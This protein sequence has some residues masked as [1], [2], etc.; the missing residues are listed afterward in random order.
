M[1]T[2]TIA[3]TIKTDTSRS[4]KTTRTIVCF[5]ILDYDSLTYVSVGD[6]H[7]QVVA[8]I[9]KKVTISHTQDREYL[10]NAQASGVTNTKL[11]SFPLALTELDLTPATDN[12][13]YSG[14][15]DVEYI[16]CVIIGEKKYTKSLGNVSISVTG[17]YHMSGKNKEL[18]EEGGS[19]FQSSTDCKFTC[20]GER[21][22]GVSVN[23]GKE[24]VTFSYDLEKL[25]TTKELLGSGLDS[26]VNL[27]DYNGYW[28]K[29]SRV[30]G[31]MNYYGIEDSKIFSYTGSPEET[32]FSGTA[33]F[34]DKVLAIGYKK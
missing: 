32:G 29:Y 19:T 17:N 14:T 7:V 23:C 9:Y 24:M 30:V 2:F 16:L 22:Y 1:G 25:D 5:E 3:G 18:I 11:S 13:D 21:L 27:E 15:R 10:I 26:P 4:D 34:P 33:G 8:L 28:K 6:K 12:Y 31:V 20:T